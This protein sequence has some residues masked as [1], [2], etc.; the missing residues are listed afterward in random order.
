[1][2]IITILKILDSWTSTA[3]KGNNRLT[4]KALIAALQ[5]NI[6]VVQQYNGM[7]IRQH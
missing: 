4:L 5:Y 1:M 3:S 6:Y 7:Q 2:N